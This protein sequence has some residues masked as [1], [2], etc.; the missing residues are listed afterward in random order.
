MAK[1]T[2]SIVE[3]MRED[4][5]SL[6]ERRKDKEE[7]KT[8]KKEIKCLKMRLLA[9]KAFKDDIRAIRNRVNRIDSL[10]YASEHVNEKPIGGEK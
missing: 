2:L 9:D 4:R 5:R 7:L 10:I 6:N 3:E 8:L 1:I